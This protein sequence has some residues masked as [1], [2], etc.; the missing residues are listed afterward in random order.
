MKNLRENLN[1]KKV[2]GF[3]W[4]FDLHGVFKIYDEVIKNH[5]C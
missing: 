1:S 3:T 2:Y 4:A 5:G